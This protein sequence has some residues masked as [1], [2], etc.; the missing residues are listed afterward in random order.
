M[1][2]TDNFDPSS[3]NYAQA[4]EQ[5]ICELRQMPAFNNVLRNQLSSIIAETEKAA[6]DIASRLQAIDQVVTD[7]GAL[8]DKSSVKKAD[9]VAAVRDSNQRLADMF[10]TVIASVQF[11]DVTRQQ[12]ELVVGA[13]DRIDSHSLSLAGYLE[14]HEDATVAFEPLAEHLDEIYSQYVMESQ[15]NSHHQAADAPDAGIESVTKVELF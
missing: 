6:F 12:I 5:V 4:A 15:R 9:L 3:S 11:Q 14:N 13:L 7:L 1:S 2:P 10:M 8:L